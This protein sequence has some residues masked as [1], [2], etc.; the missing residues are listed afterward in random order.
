MSAIDAHPP[1]SLRVSAADDSSLT[2]DDTASGVGAGLQPLPGPDGTHRGWEATTVSTA[3]CDMCHKQRCGTIQKCSECKLSVCMDCAVADRLRTDARHSLDPAAVDW[4]GSPALSRLRRLRA[5]RNARVGRG[6]RHGATRSL[7]TR[8]RARR[9]QIPSRP[10]PSRATS[11]SV[12]STV[13]PPIHVVSPALDDSDDNAWDQ[14]YNYWADEGEMA[15]Q[16][17]DGA[18]VL[19]RRP[20]SRVTKSTSP[21]SEQTAQTEYAAEI[22]VQMPCHRPRSAAEQQR[23]HRPHGP[24]HGVLLPPVH[25]VLDPGQS[26]LLPPLRT[27][28][29]QLGVETA[30]MRPLT[31]ENRHLLLPRSASSWTY[32]SDGGITEDMQHEENGVSSYE[33]HRTQGYSTWDAQPP[34][35]AHPMVAATHCHKSEEP[36]VYSS[37]LPASTAQYPP[38]SPPAPPRVTDWEEAF[39]EYAYGSYLPPRHDDRLHTHGPSTGYHAADYQSTTSTSQAGAYDYFSTPTAAACSRRTWR[40][41]KVLGPRNPDR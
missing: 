32:T 39:T 28:H 17:D 4:T 41:A 1:A 31:P 33:H 19:H 12:S 30:Q 11:T 22:L 9:R 38:R 13:S 26:G 16:P 35:Y 20:V 18:V 25:P 40:R 36:R 6:L 3:K 23:S 34:S 27:L 14:G 5:S 10:A 7:R 24:T 2:R 29:P 21:V 8:A 37:F 15:L